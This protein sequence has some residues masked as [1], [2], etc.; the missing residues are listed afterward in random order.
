LQN[1]DPRLNAFRADLADEALRDQVKAKR[2]VKGVVHQIRN[3]IAPILKRPESSAPQT[4][5]AL[6]GETCLV[7]ENK[8]GW[9]WVQMVADHYVGY[10]SSDALNAEVLQPTHRVIESSTL[11][12]P[13]ADLKT[14]PV[15]FLLLNAQVRVKTI[16]GAYSQLETGG[17]VFTRHL[18]PLTHRESDFVA[19]AEKFLHAPY[20]WGG[21]SVHG[22]DCS[23]LLQTALHACGIFAPRDSDM[24]E[25]SLGTLQNDYKDFARGDLMFWPGHVGIM[26]NATQ[27]LH[28]NGYAMKT[29]SEPLAYVVARAE[30]PISAIKRL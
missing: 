8:N 26:Q 30:M 11:L 14:G 5:Q 20:F 6:M 28:A 7:F 3:P 25:A 13:Q 9:A 27:L 12:Y 22:I 21:K 10:I 15:L 19:V 16:E 23:G 4:S 24:Q 18:A 2:F 1:L 17:F 29:T